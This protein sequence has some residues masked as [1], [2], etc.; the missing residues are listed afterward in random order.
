MSESAETVVRKYLAAWKRSDL[1]ELVSFISDD[2]VFTDGPRGVHHGIDAIR[3][4]LETMAKGRSEHLH[5]HQETS[6]QRWHGHGRAS[7]QLQTRRQTFRLGSRR[8]VRRRRQRSNQALARL[9]RL[10]VARRPHC[11]RRNRSA[12]LTVSTTRAKGALGVVA[13]GSVSGWSCWFSVPSFWEWNRVVAGEWVGSGVVVPEGWMGTVSAHD[14][15]VA[16]GSVGTALAQTLAP[17][18]LADRI[19][20]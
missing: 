10:E 9:L 20:S 5:R 12:K 18:P 1:D 8:G 2:A 6:R 15:F 13:G 16:N 4:E 3:A 7:G 11:V 14:R 17:P 19:R